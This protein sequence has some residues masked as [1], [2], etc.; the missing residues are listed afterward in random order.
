ME[1][2]FVVLS[3]PDECSYLPNERAQMRYELA[4]HLTPDVYMTRLR[5]GWRR[6]GP[7]VFRNECPTCRK[8]QSL[9]VPV[10]SFRPSTSQR[11]VWARNVD[12]L[13]VRVGTPMS[14]PEKLALFHRFHRHGHQ[15]K[16]WPTDPGHDL[17]LFINNPFPTEEWSY[18]VGERLVGVGYVDVLPEGLSA[19]YFFHEP[20]EAKRSLGTFNLLKTIEVA[21]ERRLPHVYLGYYVQGCRSLE[22]KARFTPNEKLNESGE[23]IP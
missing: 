6:F 16:G 14:S 20:D 13:Q 17:R 21:R 12:D 19:I 18:Y 4:P 3:A 8:C 2:T 22:Y 9:R 1:P 11:R 7:I 10:N 23:W 15:T 5:E